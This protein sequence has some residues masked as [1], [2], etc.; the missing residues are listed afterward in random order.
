MTRAKERLY[1]TAA[2]YYG[3][4]KRE[5]KLSPFVFEALGKSFLEKENAAAQADQLSFL[6]YGKKIAAVETPAEN[7]RVDYL[8]FS[9][10][11]TFKTCP[12]HY[13]LKYV[14]KIPTPQTASQSFGTTIHATLKEFYQEKLRG[15]KIDIKLLL[16]LFE[17]NWL[18]EGYVSKAQEQ[19]F[20]EKG[21]DYLKGFWREGYNPR[22]KTVALELPFT[23]PLRSNSEK[24]AG[25]L[26]IGGRLDRVDIFRD[27]EIEII[28]YKTGA[29][30]PSQKEVDKN[31]QLSFYALAA[32]QIPTGPLGKSPEKIK[33]SLYYL[34][35]QE[36]I[37][38][39]RTVV[40]LEEAVKE[41]FE[42][43]D[44]IENSEFACSGH[45]FCQG[46]CEYSLFCRTE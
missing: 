36:K 28:D 20:L 15:R 13:K 45:M 4:G 10:I 25:P 42:I 44:E 35:S 31:L 27:G 26:K 46:K 3:E 18:K 39:Q 8:S 14:Y 34:D 7:I 22:I 9:Q 38:T 21:I 30:I 40:Q 43:R 24:G 19:Q 2:D 23:L 29:T 6:S 16:K 32:T 11:E 1:L 37:T 33:L 5:K 41:I 12:L 17:K